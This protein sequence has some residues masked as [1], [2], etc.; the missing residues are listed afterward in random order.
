MKWLSFTVLSVLLCWATAGTAQIEVNQEPLVFENAEQEARFN[1]LT[2]E[3]RCLVCQNQ[4][5]ADSDAPLAHDLREEI[6]GM[7]MAGKDDDEIKTFLVERYGDFVLYKPPVKGNTLVLWVAPIA[8]LLIGAIVVGVV[9]RR[10]A[11][12]PSPGVEGSDQ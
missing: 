5:L 8:L 1:Q 7:M 11:Q 2:L 6:H 4:N 12:L 3:L 9:V 10:Q